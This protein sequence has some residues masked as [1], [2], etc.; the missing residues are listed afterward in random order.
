MWIAS[1]VECTPG[2]A[3]PTLACILPPADRGLNAAD[4]PQAF[5]SLNS[6]RVLARHIL[7]PP[8]FD[9]FNGAADAPPVPD[10]VQLDH[11]IGEEI[12]HIQRRDR[13]GE[14]ADLMREDGSQFLP[15]QTFD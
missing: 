13:L 8:A 1:P 15:A 10:G 12:G 14:P 9:D 2:T 5:P 3:T 11:R 6:Q 4:H 7:L